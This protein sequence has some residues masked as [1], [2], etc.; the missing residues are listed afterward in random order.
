MAYRPASTRRSSDA[1]SNA[2]RR[3]RC[4][5]GSNF[6]IKFIART[7]SALRRGGCEERASRLQGLA[8][9]LQD[10]EVK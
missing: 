9:P 5:N 7:T 3:Y 6:L 8:S 10:P 2:R 4:A 1:V